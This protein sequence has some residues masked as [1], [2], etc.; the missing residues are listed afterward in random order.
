MSARVF[1]G[2]ALSLLAAALLGQPLSLGAASRD[3]ISFTFTV[4][5]DLFGA[6]RAPGD[7][8]RPSDEFHQAV[9][10]VNLLR[11]DLVLIAGDLIQGYTADEALIQEEWD[12]FAEAV[13]RLE[14]PVN[15]APGNH[16]IWSERSK[17]IW[18]ERWGPVYYSFTHRGCRFIALNNAY[19]KQG[20]NIRGEQL[21]WLEKELR[22]PGAR[23]TFV[24][25]HKPFW[26]Y[27]EGTTNWMTEIHPLLVEA[28]VEAV[29]AGHWHH[30]EKS[31][32]RD[33]VR[34]YINGG[35]GGD[36]WQNPYAGDFFHHL[37][38]EV[39]RRSMEPVRVRVL[40]IGFLEE[41]TVVTE[42]L[43]ETALDLTKAL[44]PADIQVRE[45]EDAE[46]TVKIQAVNPHEAPLVV[47]HEME[48]SQS[49]SW[50]M[51]P[52]PSETLIPPGE[53]GV[54]WLRFR[55]DGEELLPGPALL[56]T[57]TVEGETVVK[58]SGRVGVRFD[59]T[60]EV[61]RPEGRI[62]VDG[63]LE[64]AWEG[65]ASA[66]R[67]VAFNGSSYAGLATDFR[68][69][70]DDAAIYLSFRCD[71]PG[72]DAIEGQL[73][74]RDWRGLSEDCVIFYLD[75]VRDGATR[76]CFGST[77]MGVPI[78]YRAP[79]GAVDQAWN[80]DWEWA[81]SRDAEGW[82][83][84]ARIPFAIL[85]MKPDDGFEFGLN[86]FRKSTSGNGELTCWSI[87][88]GGRLSNPNGFGTAV[89]K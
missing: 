18:E 38:V 84:E 3:D 65:C 51:A 11:P 46:V 30:Y 9:R 45:G 48:A 76:Y 5:A 77:A 19:L 60:L 62:D 35:L 8:V 61:G 54:I 56:L 1:R 83:L 78:D 71:Q 42:E 55:G 74:E 20:D 29:F 53:E 57:A 80:P 32:E 47:R 39:P 22:R 72:A 89:L 13:G 86:A 63:V 43:R 28:G 25:L 23:R 33:G 2:L 12:A 34:Y 73:T 10:E 4:M 36:Q 37:L 49:G 79:G 44:E 70:R 64:D 6:T 15:L 31:T 26:R 66:G 68:A 75:P 67:F 24:F 52:D 82:T 88:E 50:R 69:C 27:R 14:M 58:T 87:P 59:R 41:D 21:D 40:K 81:V 16:D 7:D 17:E 85:D